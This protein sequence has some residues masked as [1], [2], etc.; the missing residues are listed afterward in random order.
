MWYCLKAEPVASRHQTLITEPPAMELVSFQEGGG[1]KEGSFT[2]YSLKWGSEKAAVYSLEEGSPWSPAVPHSDSRLP[3]SGTVKKHCLSLI[4][5]TEWRLARAVQTKTDE[6]LVWEAGGR[7]TRSSLYEIV[8]GKHPSLSLV[9]PDLEKSYFYLRPDFPAPTNAANL[10]FL[11][12][13]CK[14]CRSTFCHHSWALA[15]FYALFLNNNQK[16]K[17]TATT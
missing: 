4:N 6:L 12:A 15:C 7:L 5:H 8:S 2:F 17:Y 3:A 11:A 1:G 14:G 16:I 13:S 9:G 10:V